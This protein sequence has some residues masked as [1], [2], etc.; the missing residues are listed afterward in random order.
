MTWPVREVQH[1]RI[2][3]LQ[4]MHCE[5]KVCKERIAYLKTCLMRFIVFFTWTHGGSVVWDL[6]SWA[7]LTL[8]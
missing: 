5:C 7:G 2:L 1:A 4:V 6:F 3:F 8:P